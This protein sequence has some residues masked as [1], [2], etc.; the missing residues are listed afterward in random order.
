MTRHI[1]SNADIVFEFMLAGKATI[2]IQSTETE[3]HYTYRITKANYNKVWFV[4]L[5]TSSDHYT[6]MG[7]IRKGIFGTTAKSSYSM[8]TTPV[9]A[10][11]YFFNHLK[12][13]NIAPKLNVYHEGKCGMC[14][15]PLTTP[16]SIER[17]I[18]PICASYQG[19]LF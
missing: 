11:L 19:S 1:M 10:F 2:T 5:L 9:K 13:R 7:I 3:V 15:R 6:Y 14:N 12:G 18:G 16:E 4:S 17:G 8:E